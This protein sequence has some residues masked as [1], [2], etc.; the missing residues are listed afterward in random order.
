MI[1]NS[2][3]KSVLTYRSDTKHALVRLASGERAIVSGG[4]GGID[5]PRGAVSRVICPHAPPV[6]RIA[7]FP[8]EVKLRVAERRLHLRLDRTPAHPVRS[9]ISHYLYKEWT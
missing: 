2:T 8:G 1:R 7:D 3:A 5:F 9:T 6:D 4:P